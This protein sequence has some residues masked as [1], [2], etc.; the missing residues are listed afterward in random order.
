MP[1]TLAT[2]ARAANLT[3]APVVV[4][5]LRDVM[6]PAPAAT[7]RT[8]VLATTVPVDRDVMATA[9]NAPSVAL[10]AVAGVT[11]AG[12]TVVATAVAKNIASRSCPFRTSTSL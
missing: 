7:T 3:T 9:P 12:T 11:F 1:N 10:L 6:A 2:R 8:A 4:A 5:A